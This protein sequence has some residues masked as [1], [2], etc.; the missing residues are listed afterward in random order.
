MLEKQVRRMLADRRSRALVENFAGQWLYLRNVATVKPDGVLFPEFNTELRVAVERETK[1][2]FEK[3]LRHNRSVFDL[4]DADYT[5]LNETL[6][7]H[8]GVGRVYGPQFREVQLRDSRRG[9]LLGQASIL[10]V[11]SY[12]NRTS[13]TVRGKWILEN[14]FSMPPPPQPPD[15]PE[16]EE[17][18]HDGKRLTLREAMSLHSKNPTCASCHVRMDPI[19][20]ALENYDAIGRWRTE[21]AGAPIDASG[22][23]PGGVTFNG[24][25][26]LKQVLARD[27]G[28]AFVATV[29]E[30]LLAYALGRGV[31]YYD[32]ATVRSIVRQAARNEYRL[33][34]L[35]VTIVQSTP[36]QMR[37]SPES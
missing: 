10:T 24:P 11:T 30:K 7:E 35:I 37:R 27:F 22:E 1:L 29:A 5:F 9:G 13:V 8:Y 19:G 3:I 33:A 14:L 2:F 36:F 15:V 21:D 25:G 34:D 16:L 28:D 18:N 4:L 31:E 6:A 12:P 26:E 20:F 32:K 17:A 23:L